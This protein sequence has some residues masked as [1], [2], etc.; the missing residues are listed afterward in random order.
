VQGVSGRSAGATTCAATRVQWASGRSAG[1]L[2]VHLCW[3]MG[4]SERAL[5][6]P[7]AAQMLNQTNIYDSLLMV[8][9]ILH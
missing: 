7:T 3:R 4:I 5:T 1:V 8:K 6:V 9:Y 2:H